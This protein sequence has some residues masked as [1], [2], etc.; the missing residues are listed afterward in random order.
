[1]GTELET[2]ILSDLFLWYWCGGTLCYLA[3]KCL[4]LFSFTFHRIA[5][6]RKFRLL[7]LAKPTMQLQP[8]EEQ[9]LRKWQIAHLWHDLTAHLVSQEN[10]SATKNSHDPVVSDSTLYL[11]K[12]PQALV[13]DARLSENLAHLTRNVGSI[14]TGLGVLGT[15]IGLAAGVYSAREGLASADMA[16]LQ[17]AISQMLRGAGLAF[18]TSVFGLGASL[19]HTKIENFCFKLLHAESRLIRALTLKTKYLSPVQIQVSL[20]TQQVNNGEILARMEHHIA[21]ATAVKVEINQHALSQVVDNFRSLFQSLF[22]SEEHHLQLFALQAQNMAEKTLEQLQQ[23][24]S[25]LQIATKSMHETL[26]TSNH[27]LAED[28]R[29][30]TNESQE[31]FTKLLDRITTCMASTDQQVQTL[32]NLKIKTHETDPWG[33]I[34]LVLKDLQKDCKVLLTAQTEKLEQGGSKGAFENEVIISMKQ[35]SARLK[36]LS[37]GVA[38]AIF[39]FE[40]MTEQAHVHQ[41]ENLALILERLLQSQKSEKTQ[42]A[43]QVDELTNS[44]QKLCAVANSRLL[45]QE[46]KA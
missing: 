32:S 8:K 45:R 31:K 5:Q 38:R 4:R 15:F 11:L 26:V 40:K 19:F 3:W 44:V 43:F 24:V 1:M 41:D 37:E 28:T 29:R 34:A 12:T 42:L 18:I 6:I 14:L 21:Q 39:K 33:E 16:I 30:A 20:Y 46:L 9:Q 7:V 35:Q 10:P 27:N 13:D 22:A 36:D 17:E 2:I 25:G 23:T